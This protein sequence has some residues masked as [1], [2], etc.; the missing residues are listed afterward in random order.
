MLPKGYYL[1][2][3]E[4][5]H[6]LVDKKDP[7]KIM[8]E[9]T[10]MM[11][12]DD[13]DDSNAMRFHIRE[14]YITDE[15][16]EHVRKELAKATTKDGHDYYDCGKTFKELI[17]QEVDPDKVMRAVKEKGDVYMWVHLIHA[18][19]EGFNRVEEAIR[20]VSVDEL[21]DNLYY[22]LFPEDDYE[23]RIQE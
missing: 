17:L 2:K 9:C 4:E 18:H 14:M 12:D 7:K 19:H 8:V 23:G 13:G 22:K 1:M 11:S 20:P 5:L 6:Y 10:L 15:E 16:K 21:P 3:M